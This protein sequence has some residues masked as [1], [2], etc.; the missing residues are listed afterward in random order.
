MA[1]DLVNRLSS[2]AHCTIFDDMFEKIGA[3]QLA[4][5]AVTKISA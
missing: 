5:R 4:G 2:M 3:G 1:R